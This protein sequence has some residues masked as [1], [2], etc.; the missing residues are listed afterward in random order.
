MTVNE[1]NVGIKYN[2]DVA[3]EY[4]KYL[5][6]MAEEFNLDC[7]VRVST[8]SRYPEVFS[9]A[10]GNRYFMAKFKTLEE[11]NLFKEYVSRRQGDKIVNGKTSKKTSD[12]PICDH[13][14]DGA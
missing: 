6:E 8:L 5:K 11:M 4:L 14:V 10:M 3:A 2:K 9:G 12:G 1:N 7:D 13:H